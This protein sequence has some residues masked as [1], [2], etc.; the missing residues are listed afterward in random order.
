MSPISSV[1]DKIQNKAV[2]LGA[3][4]SVAVHYANFL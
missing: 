3:Q 2:K 1:V 4:E